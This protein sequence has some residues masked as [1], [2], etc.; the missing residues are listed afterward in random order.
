MATSDLCEALKRHAAAVSS[1]QATSSSTSNPRIDAETEKKICLAVLR[2]LDDK[3]NDVQTIAVKTLG[4]LVTSVHEDQVVT[5]AEKLAAQVLDPTKSGLRDVYAIGLRTLVKTVPMPMGDIVSHRLAAR[6]M[7]GI[8]THSPKL[9]TNP[10]VSSTATKQEKME[11]KISEEILLYSLEILNDL[12]T[13]FGALPFITRQHE[14]LL[15]VTLKQLSSSSKMVRKRASNTIGCLSVCISDSLLVRLVDNLLMEISSDSSKKRKRYNTRRAQ[16]EKEETDKSIDTRALI[17]TMCT[18]SGV[19]GHRLGQV[20]IDRM[21]PLFLKFCDVK[22]AASGDDEYDDDDDEEEENDGDDEEMEDENEEEDEAAIAL[23]NELRESC[24]TGFQSFVLRRPHEVKPHLPQIIHAAL[25]YM[26]Y[27]PNYSYGDEQKTN[28]DDMDNDGE[29]DFDMSDDENEDEDDYEDIS[30]DDDDESWKVR[31]SAIRTLTAVIEAFQNDLSKLWLDEYSW[32]KNKKRKATVAGALVQRFK[33]REENCRVDVFECFNRLLSHSVDNKPNSSDSIDTV[34]TD[35]AGI[36][37]LLTSDF[38]SAVVTGCEKQLTAKKGGLRTKS[39][40]LSLL[41][42]L[43][44]A[45]GGVGGGTQIKS[46]LTH[47]QQI[48]GTTGGSGIHGSNKGLKLDALCLVRKMISCNSHEPVHIK[49]GVISVLLV[50]LCKAAQEDWYKIIGETLRVL[51]EIPAL[52]VA[53][54]SDSN[55]MKNVASSLYTAIEPRLAANDL[56]QEIKECSLQGCATLLAT[57][58]HSLDEN[59]RNRLL[60]LIVQRLK[61]ET[62]RISA[63]KTISFIATESNEK[64]GAVDLSFILDDVVTEL[65]NLLRQNSRG[66]KQTSLK[67]LET[68]TRSHGKSVASDV[69]FDKVLGELSGIIVDTDLHISHLSLLAAFAI[70]EV[71]PSNCEASAKN[72]LLPAMLQF[73]SSSIVQDAALDSLLPVLDKLVLTQIVAFKELLPALQ[74]KLPSQSAEKE[75]SGSKQVIA[76]LAKCIATITASANDAEKAGV[77]AAL[78]SS[79]QSTGPSPENIQLALRTSGDLGRIFNLST[80]NGVA[81][82]LQSIYLSFFDSKAEEIKNAAAYGLGRASVGALPTFL[83]KI[84]SALEE[85]DQKK[86]YLLLSSLRELIH[87]LHDASESDISP[88]IQE[89]FPHLTQHCSDTE[90]GVRTMVADCLGSLACLRPDDILPQLQSMATQHSGKEVDAD[91][92]IVEN[93]D[94]LV[95]WTLATSI[96]YAIAGGCDSKK[97]LPF[98]PVFLN[99]LKEQDLSVKN[100]ALLMVYSSVHHNPELVLGFMQDQILPSLHEVCGMDR[101]FV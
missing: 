51:S 6:L 39:A 79:L 46:V 94:A 90:E 96:K 36:D 54:N 13:R 21:V 33:E 47:I 24:F 77:V 8:Q 20:Q 4:V 18:V 10:M 83:P 73:V 92:P 98:M 41:S 37:S 84:L 89:I 32:K 2:L 66:V 97:L 22:E 69:L 75:L 16:E 7:D 3:S 86:Q 57:L 11:Y 29:D 76:N 5:I 56:D 65:A 31:R 81:E 1:T 15:Q 60:S 48:L 19:V 17:Q 59:Q 63:I 93:K 99:L 26:R 78:I 82:S 100:T 27:D 49:D 30:D 42:T 28:E 44:E 50:E 14:T 52:L 9:D 45:P 87:C 64:Y 67:C 25:A 85:N 35:T 61:N 58:H 101:F 38:V 88:S 70:L 62:T 91:L 55:E 34:M 72:K 53:A 40:A 71:S 43:C 23:A 80:M 68:L 74:A 12:L 95:C